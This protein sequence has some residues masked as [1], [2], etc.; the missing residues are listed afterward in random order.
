MQSIDLTFRW[1]FSSR[2][3]YG[4]YYEKAHESKND[5]IHVDPFKMMV[6]TFVHEVFHHLEPKA[7]H[8]RIDVLEDLIVWYA[9]PRQMKNLFQ[10]LIHYWRLTSVERRGR[11]AASPCPL[12]GQWFPRAPRKRSARARPAKV[13]E[14][15]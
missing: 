3:L 13:V 10:R 12:C 4:F 5:R 11:H 2:G 15:A 7:P 6:A 9:S 8:A 1:L 14:A